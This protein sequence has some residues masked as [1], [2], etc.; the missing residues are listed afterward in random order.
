M[1][2]THSEARSYDVLPGDDLG[3]YRTTRY[4]LTTEIS[5]AEDEFIALLI[6]KESGGRQ[7]RPVRL[8]AGQVF[9][10]SPSWPHKETPYPLGHFK[11]IEKVIGLH[12]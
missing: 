7:L 10:I 12:F 4:F 1:S 2:Q 11:T 6:D 9:V 5:E 3:F 8:E